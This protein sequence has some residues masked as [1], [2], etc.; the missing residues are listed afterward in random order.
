MTKAL[1][2]ELEM[3]FK[4]NHGGDPSS[5]MPEP[6][7]A[8]TDNDWARVFGAD[9]V[10]QTQRIVTDSLGRV[11]RNRAYFRT[12]DLRRS[13]LTMARKELPP[14]LLQDERYNQMI[15]GIIAQLPLVEVGTTG[16]LTTH[17]MVDMERRMLVLAGSVSGR[18]KLPERVVAR[19]IADK[20]GISEEQVAAVQAACRS[21]RDVTVI[22]GTAGAGKSYTM[23]AIKNAYEAMGYNVMGT[24]LGWNAA[25]VL[26][27]ETGMVSDDP[28]TQKCVALA[29][30]VKRMDIARAHNM[31]FFT[32]PTLLIVDEAGMVGTRHMCKLLDEAQRSAHPV[33]VVLTGDSLQVNPVD[34]GNTLEAIVAHHGTT[35]IDTIRRQKRASHR[36]AVRRFM[37]KMAGQGLYL[38]QQQEALRWCK[39]QEALFNRVVADFLSYKVA[40]PDKK[41]LI[42][43]L[44]N[45]EVAELNKRIR[46]VYRRLG[47]IDSREIKVKVTDSRETWEAPFSIGDEV[48]IRGNDVKLPTYTIDP[49]VSTTQP[50]RWQIHG[51]G[52]F[53]RNAGT[54]VGIAPAEH[55]AG[56][57]NITVDIRGTTPFRVMLN[58]ERFRDTERAAMPI[59][60]N[61]ATTI[62]ASQ[63]QTVNQVFLIDSARMEFRLAYVGMS[64]HT[65]GVEIYLNESELAQRLASQLGSQRR[66][67]KRSEML[68][69][70]AM[71]WSKD[72][73]NP[74]VIMYEQQ[75]RLGGGKPIPLEERARI[76][77]ASADD[78]VL[79][80]IDEL[81]QPLPQIDLKKLL[82]LP[83]HPGDAALAVD[84]VVASSTTHDTPAP[85]A[86][87]K[88][89][90]RWV[91]D[92]LGL[93]KPTEPVSAPRARDVIDPFA[94][95]GQT[96][97]VTPGWKA[98]A[99]NLANSAW[100][101]ILGQRPPVPMQPPA[102]RVGQISADGAIDFASVPST[103][104]AQGGPSNDWIKAY[105]G[106]CWDTGRHAEPRILA[107]DPRGVVQAR[108]R[109]DG[110]CVVGDGYPPLWL[111]RDHDPKTP[112]YIV[113]GPK[114]WFWMTE[115][116]Q[117][118]HL[119]SPGRRPHVIWAAKDM[120]WS[121]VAPF[122]KG[123]TVKVIRS[124]IDP[125]QA[126]W[127]QHV[128]QKLHNQWGVESVVAPPLP[129]PDRRPRR[130]P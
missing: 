7:S 14:T 107:R 41:A 113:T 106:T 123:R 75:C 37:N 31:D 4:P 72:S 126:R 49:N 8:M 78:P 22:E 26:E 116:Q 60:H 25:K 120:D 21:D 6:E 79:D 50:D 58:T 28:H 69:A 88:G 61:F 13:A 128:Q 47:F 1:L 89:W 52:V 38:Y 48:V 104:G 70:V 119:D 68:H 56:S 103:R 82:E 115:H 124:R 3:A 77:Q 54:I 86:N 111:N 9:L 73:Q 27:A 57:Y 46:Q 63:G 42:L 71:G 43:A 55:P 101:G 10:R 94:A 84:G 5:M 2:H 64:R 81:D 65:D 45:H 16:S 34:A 15:D 110:T 39:D 99:R 93:A 87:D 36:L 122:M 112:I 114:E 80:F 130:R 105:R 35:R 12:N 40:H 95:A 125:E 117:Q 67:F 29:G 85:T 108:Y 44:S 121:A 98:A 17:E 109:L 97:H 129:T 83:E 30:L 66:A 74:T 118:R 102:A 92:H 96:A 91:A 32:G 90:R 18:H 76:H 20:K 59:T 33:K 11:M 19:A 51:Q 23:Q 62:Y 100:N 53:N 24:A 127:A